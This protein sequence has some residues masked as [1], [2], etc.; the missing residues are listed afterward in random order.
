MSMKP[1]IKKIIAL[2]ENLNRYFKNEHFCENVI[3]VLV[4]VL[5]HEV[6]RGL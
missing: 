5:T 2:S 6:F 3:F 4:L 1:K